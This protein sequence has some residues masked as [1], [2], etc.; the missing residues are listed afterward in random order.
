MWG[1]LVSEAV[2]GY[3]DIYI[4]MVQGVRNERHGISTETCSVGNA[5][6]IRVLVFAEI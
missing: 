4:V 2:H 6:D 5:K 3:E 1:R